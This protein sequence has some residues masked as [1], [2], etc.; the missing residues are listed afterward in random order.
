MKARTYHSPARQE[1]AEATRR[2]IA[3]AARK[4]LL[5]KGFDKTTVA[6]IAA[7]AGVATQTVYAVFGSKEGVLRDLMDLARFGPRYRELVLEALSQTEPAARLK[8]AASIACQIFDSERAEM[9]L[10]RGAGVVSPELALM[11]RER[12]ELRFTSQ[13]PMIDLAV[14][15][16]RLRKGLDRTA[17]RHI[18]WAYTS[19]DLYRMLV[20]ERAWSSSRYEKWL[21]QTLVE[22]LLER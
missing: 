22:A 3:L 9:E 10:W 16:K 19:R 14:E 2:N 17:A 20:V 12:E 8:M 13:S 18:L 11:E 21:S 15:K 1:Q 5:E 7:A 6:A 4:L